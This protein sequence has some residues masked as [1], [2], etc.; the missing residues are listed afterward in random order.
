MSGMDVVQK[1]MC[2]SAC[3]SLICWPGINGRDVLCALYLRQQSIHQPGSLNAYRK[4]SHPTFSQP[5]GS[6]KK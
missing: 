5:E 1:Q 2:F 3:S 6:P 4:Y